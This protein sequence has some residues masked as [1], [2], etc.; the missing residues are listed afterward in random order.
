MQRICQTKAKVPRISDVF[1]TRVAWDVV[2]G[3]PGTFPL[4]RFMIKVIY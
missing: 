2:G 3:L 4:T 1:L